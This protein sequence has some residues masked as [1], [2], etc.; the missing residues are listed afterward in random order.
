MFD[1]VPQIRRN[2]RPARNS[3]FAARAA[4][5]TVGRNIDADNLRT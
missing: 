3:Q 1:H 2:F 4:S 5:S